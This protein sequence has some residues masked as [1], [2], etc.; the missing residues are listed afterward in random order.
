MSPSIRDE[1]AGDTE[2]VMPPVIFIAL[3]VCAQHPQKRFLDDVVGIGSI[4]NDAISVLRN[5]PS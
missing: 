3:D 4:T 1:M 2:Q 5:V